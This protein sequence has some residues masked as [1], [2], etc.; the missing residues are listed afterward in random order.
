MKQKGGTSFYEANSL[1]CLACACHMYYAR[2]SDEE[3]SVKRQLNSTKSIKNIISKCNPQP[4]YVRPTETDQVQML[5]VSCA[6]SGPKEE[7]ETSHTNFNARGPLQSS[8]QA[9]HYPQK[10]SCIASHASKQK[11]AKIRNT[12][13]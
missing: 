6:S 11:R 4:Y 1:Q 9:H 13:L 7:V 5:F 2:D 3:N 8:L 12:T 10:S